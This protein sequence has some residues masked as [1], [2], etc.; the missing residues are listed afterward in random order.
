VVNGGQLTVFGRPGDQIRFGNKNPWYEIVS[1]APAPSPAGALQVTFRHPLNRYSNP[2]V[3]PTENWLPFQVTF[4]PGRTRVFPALTAPLELPRGIAVDLTVSGM[5]LNG[6][7]FAP[8]TPADESDVVVMFSPQ[9][10]IERIYSSQF[11]GVASS[12]V[13]NATL[14]FLIGK[15]D[16]VSPTDWF[17]YSIPD[18]FRSNLMDAESIWVALGHKTGK[19]TVAE[20]ISLVERSPAAASEPMSALAE[21]RMFARSGQDMGGR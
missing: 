21:S 15:I 4:Q 14:F 16:Q 12:V 9:G 20:N 1:I 6:Q 10:Q 2:P 11:G 13:P 7:E 17:A 18:R 3:S 8:L 19:I 5:G